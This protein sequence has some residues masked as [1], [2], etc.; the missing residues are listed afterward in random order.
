MAGTEFPGNHTFTKTVLVNATP[1]KVWD[2][3]TRPEQM[4]Q[5]MSETELDIVTDWRVG[6]PIT[7]SGPWYKT[8]FENS[9]RVLQFE[10][11]KSLQYSHLSSLSRLPDA[12]ENYSLTGFTLVPEDD[13][14]LVTVTLS[15]FPTE[16]IYKHLAFYW[17]VAIELLKRFAER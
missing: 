11:E 1:S 8:G 9:G 14:T 4:K 6:G 7:I 2:A 15:N 10:P 16:T 12:V 17:N 13:Q 3:L 5:W